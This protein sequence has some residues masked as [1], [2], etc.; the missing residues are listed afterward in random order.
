M[1]KVFPKVIVTDDNAASS[2]ELRSLYPA[3]LQ[4]LKIVNEGLGGIFLG[5]GVGLI[6]LVHVYGISF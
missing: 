1:I 2:G 6:C 5:E 3:E 4:Q